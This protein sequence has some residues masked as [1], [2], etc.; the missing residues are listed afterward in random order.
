[1]VRV[2]PRGDTGKRPA[3]TF[4]WRETSDVIG[5]DSTIAAQPVCVGGGG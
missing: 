3:V 1:M 5:M 2:R 4:R